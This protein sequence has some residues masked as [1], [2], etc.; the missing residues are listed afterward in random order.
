MAHQK[1]VFHRGQRHLQESRYAL[2]ACRSLLP[3][4]TQIRRRRGFLGDPRPR[5]CPI[6]QS[7]RARR[8]AQQQQQPR[9]QQQQQ[10]PR[11]AAAR[12]PRGNHSRTHSSDGRRRRST[13]LVSSHSRSRLRPQAGL[14]ESRR[15]ESQHCS[16]RRRQSRAAHGS[17]RHGAARG[18]HASSVQYL[19]VST[20]QGYQVVSST[21]SRLGS[22]PEIV[23]N[24]TF[25]ANTCTRGGGDVGGWRAGGQPDCWRFLCTLWPRAQWAATQV[26][27]R[28]ACARPHS[29]IRRGVSRGP[30]RGLRQ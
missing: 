3:A 12:R 15:A 26:P 22:I 11:K 16:R 4:C 19:P 23:V 24:T 9:K 13:T 1:Q 6:A 14:S 21:E 8:I 18:M 28:H 20:S 30:R 29:A 17:G 5:S 25:E 7:Q 27:D 10:Q 2:A